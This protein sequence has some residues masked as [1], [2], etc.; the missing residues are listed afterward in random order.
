[1]NPDEVVA[2][3]AAVQAGVLSGDVK[4]L[5]LLDV[6]PLSPRRRDA[7]RRDDGD[8]PAQHDHPDAEEGD[9]LDGD[10]QPAERRDPRPPGRA[11]R[12]AVQPHPR[13]VPPRGHHAGAARRAQGRGHVR[14]RRER[15][16]LRPREG[17]GD[18]QGPEDHHH[19]ELGPERG[20]DP[21]DGEGG[22]R[23]TRREDKERR[24]QIERR[25]KLD[26]LCYTLEKTLTE[27]KDKIP[28]AD[29]STLEGLIKEGREA[30]EKQDDAKVQDVSERLEKEAHRLA[31]RHV[32]RAA[33]APAARAERR[34]ASGTRRRCRRR[35]R[36][37]RAEGRRRHRRRVRRD[38][39]LIPRS[40]SALAREGQRD[41][42][43]AEQHAGQRSTSAGDPSPSSAVGRSR[44]G[45]RRPYGGTI[46]ASLTA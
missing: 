4:D 16:P 30:V 15:H 6:T 9:L 40:L 36:A 24:E 35:R 18:G 8:D 10:R 23:S 46:G 45:R 42:G 17:H 19:R 34:A 1:M 20:R 7:R 3:G 5:V 33:G 14:H 12:G 28:A 44:R 43:V 41:V 2:V 25:N 27:N 13:Q 39:R 32:R 31:E 26:N 22:R 21:E 37:R 38:R 29:L 11:H